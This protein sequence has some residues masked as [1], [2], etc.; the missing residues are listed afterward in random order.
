V[1][2]I[3]SNQCLCAHSEVHTLTLCFTGHISTGIQRENL[4]NFSVTPK[5]EKHSRV[6]YCTLASPH[7]P[8][9]V[10]HTCKP[11]FRQ[12]R[13]RYGARG[14]GQWSRAQ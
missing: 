13:A 4:T 7:T 14:W 12:R 11:Y 10:S 3:P 5:P 6:I 2:F 1:S 9:T 8:Y